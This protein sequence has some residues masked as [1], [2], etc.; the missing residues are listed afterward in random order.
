MP[1]NS[2]KYVD[3]VSVVGGGS[4]V[5]SRELKLRIFT[6]NDLVPTGSILNFTDSDQVLDYFGSDSEE[7]VMSVY[8][9]GY[10]SKVG[11]RPKSINF[12]RWTSTD[13]S[14]KI[15]G[16]EAAELDDLIAI[17]DGAI[18]IT[19][20]QEDAALTGLDFS[21]SATYADVADVLQTAIQAEGGVF[22]SA[23]VTFE[24]L[25]SA[26][27]FDT[28]SGASDGEISASSSDGTDELLGWGEDAIFSDGIAAETVTEVL[29]NSTEINNNF[30][31]YEFIIEL[32]D[33]QI[34][35]SA[36]WN[37]ARNVEFQYQTR[38]NK[39][40]AVSFFDMLKG[41]SGTGVTIIVPA[42]DQ[43]PQL[44]PCALLASQ[45]WDNPAASANYM[46][47][48]DGRLRATVTNT[49]ESNS[50]DANRMNYM[51]QTQEAG[52]MIEFYQRG[53]LMGDSTAPLSMG[54]Y[55][56]EQWLKSHLKS[57]FLNMFLALQQVPTDDAGI[58]IGSSYIDAAVAQ[59]VDN[60]AISQGK[61][62]TTDQIN[63]IT[64][65]TGDSNAYLDV[66]SRG[67]WYRIDITSSV[68]ENGVTEYAM[69]YL[70]VYAK[71]D[72]VDK[73]AGR[74]NLI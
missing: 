14:A 6:T 42:H 13:S 7:Y 10:V 35:E 71:R 49:A 25:R 5:G 29:S 54:V 53:V 27:H 17:T 36:A 67:F 4:T 39:S 59:G 3:I 64:Q 72:S 9:F 22:S 30:G 15:L 47:Q 44:L 2:G 51:G 12:A 56:N 32:T 16:S 63:F 60:G 33:E 48:Q 18:T 73:V 57:A 24:S 31:S 43:Y 8:Y 21:S 11:T 58:A 69:E 50:L 34:V 23:D 19:V 40:Q 45:E 52:A 55:A 20:G 26:F 61:D 41:Y 65:V 1:I 74:H 37:H 70:L 66:E 62:L 38:C 28:N 68:A 46:Y